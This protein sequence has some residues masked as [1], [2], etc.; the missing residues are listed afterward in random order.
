MIRLLAREGL[1]VLPKIFVLLGANDDVINIR[2]G[3][4]YCCVASSTSLPWDVPPNPSDL[5]FVERVVMQFQLPLTHVL[6]AL[7]ATTL[8]HRS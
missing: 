5:P 7:M 8:Q 2:Y 3:V 6:L 1:G 4:I